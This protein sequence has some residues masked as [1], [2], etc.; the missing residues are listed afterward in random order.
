MAFTLIVVTA[1][2]VIIPF[3]GYRIGKTGYKILQSITTTNF[4]R[5]NLSRLLSRSAVIGLIPLLFLLTSITTGAT[6]IGIIDISARAQESD[7]GLWVTLAGFIL[8]IVAGIIIS[9]AAGFGEQL[10]KSVSQKPGSHEEISDIKPG[11][12]TP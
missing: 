6:D 7:V 10:A 9:L 3:M 1:I 12:D 11:F 8:A 5:R 4:D 2:L